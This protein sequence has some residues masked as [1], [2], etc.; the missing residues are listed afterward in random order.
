MIKEYIERIH[1]LKQK[2]PALELDDIYEVIDFVAETH[3]IYIDKVHEEYIRNL[4]Y[5]APYI[6]KVYTIT[7]DM[8]WPY[9][10]KRIINGNFPLEDIPT[11]IRETAQ[12]L[13]YK[14]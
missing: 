6:E 3:D 8:E 13:Y 2:K 5:I 10:A 4:F 11:H 14:E 9:Q 12:N 7:E 1:C